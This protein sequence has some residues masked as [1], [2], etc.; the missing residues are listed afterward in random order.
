MA[1]EGEGIIFLGHI[2]NARDASLAWLRS[3][4]SIPKLIIE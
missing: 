3:Q 4:A 1:V 2:S